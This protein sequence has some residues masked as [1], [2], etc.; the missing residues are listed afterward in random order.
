MECTLTA[1]VCAL[2]LIV[3][4]VLVV[5]LVVIYKSSEAHPNLRRFD[6]EEYFLEPKKNEKIKFPSIHDPPSV[7][8]TVVV[9]AYN[10]EERLPAM[11]NEAIDYLEERQKMTPSFSYEILVV[12]DGSKDKTTATGH[13]Y[14][15]KYGV[16]KVRVLTLEKNRGKG[17]AVRLGMFSAR[18]KLLLFADADGASQFK[19]YRK[20][21]TEMLKINKNSNNLAVVCGSRAHLEKDAIAE[22]SLFRTFLM[23]GF[24]FLVWFLCVRGIK[25]TQCGFKLLTR[26]AA[27]VL[28]SNLHVE[29]W[30]FDVEMLYLAQCFNMRISEV[31]ITWQEIEG[32]KMVPV[33][34]W[35]QMG[36]DLLLIRLRYVIGAWKI[37]SKVKKE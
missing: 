27:I 11:M 20:L 5:V 31:A 7:D 10:E 36:K 30:A 14:S 1:I 19:D 17:G 4:V 18:G 25:D 9:P 37:N 23:K 13:L 2:L 16:D 24:H 22:R 21:E 15:S 26:D 12:D 3:I 8:L 32:S 34:S 28:F 33:W 6:S 29:R 35:L